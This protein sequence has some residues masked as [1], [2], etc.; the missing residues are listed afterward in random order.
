MINQNFYGSNFVSKGTQMRMSLCS[1]QDAQDAWCLKRAQ[2][3]W[4]RASERDR[5]SEKEK[6]ETQGTDREGIYCIIRAADNQ[7]RTS[8]ETMC[9]ALVCVGE[10]GEPGP[11]G[12]RPAGSC[13][14]VC[15][16]LHPFCYYY[17]IVCFSNSMQSCDHKIAS[18]LPVNIN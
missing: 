12:V 11:R 16:Q 5:D 9:C 10:K 4:N 7:L 3:H 15:S 18:R 6:K 1:S 13:K 14:A 2:V 8:F 17:F